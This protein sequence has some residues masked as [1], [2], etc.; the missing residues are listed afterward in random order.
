MGSIKTNLKAPLLCRWLGIGLLSVFSLPLFAQSFSLG[1]LFN[2]AA[3]QKQYY[4]QQIAAYY[5]FESELKM[6]Y[7][8]MKHGLNGIA[9][10]NTTELDA[11]DAYYR[12]L[13]QPSELVKNSRLVQDIISWQSSIITQFS[14]LSHVT[15]LTSDEQN[16][17]GSVQINLVKGCNEDV[18]DLQNLLQAGTL[19]MTDDQRL[20]RMAQ[21]YADMLEKYQFT[22]SFAGSVRLLAAQRHQDTNDTQTLKNFYETN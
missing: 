5:A 11:H 2:Q 3:K 10:I 19:Q 20:K 4:L 15:G 7:N 18:I 21:L 22:Q 6:G 17:I 8:V 16:Y 12:S 13:L 9:Q 1:D 14:T